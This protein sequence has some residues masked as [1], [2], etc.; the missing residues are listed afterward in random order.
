MCIE[1]AFQHFHFMI[2][3]SVDSFVYDEFL[4]IT[5]SSV[6]SN[7]LK[8]WICKLFWFT[9]SGVL[10]Q[11]FELKLRSV[12]WPVSRLVAKIDFYWRFKS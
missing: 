6:F 11:K 3:E 1:T 8:L 7:L 5:G 10:V 12:C 2:L 9:E 4:G